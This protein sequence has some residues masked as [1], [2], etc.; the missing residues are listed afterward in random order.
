MNQSNKNGKD[1]HCRQNLKIFFSRYHKRPVCIWK[2]S[3]QLHK[4]DD[5]W[6]NY[7]LTN[8]FG[9]KWLNA[10]KECFRSQ[11][12]TSSLFRHTV[13]YVSICCSIYKLNYIYKPN[14]K[15]ASCSASFLTKHSNAA[16]TIPN[17]TNIFFFPLKD[18]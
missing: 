2:L 18:S 8:L 17:W 1:K 12:L 3:I 16:F 6:E 7:L 13:I 4:Q 11:H 9:K 5:S 14:Y 15:P 10:L